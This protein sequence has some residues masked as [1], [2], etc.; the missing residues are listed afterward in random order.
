MAGAEPHYRALRV[1]DR[2]LKV[3][4]CVLLAARVPF[5][6]GENTKRVQSLPIASATCLDTLAPCPDSQSH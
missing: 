4:N 1:S 3:T 5:L 2:T 6:S